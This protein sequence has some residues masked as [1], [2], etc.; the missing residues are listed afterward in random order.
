M[1]EEDSGEEQ[2]QA[3]MFSIT[4]SKAKEQL[5]PTIEEDELPELLEKS[6]SEDEEDITI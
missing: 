1:E 6:D 4:K 5:E 3:F 2:S